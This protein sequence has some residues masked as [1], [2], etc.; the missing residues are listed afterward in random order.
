MLPRASYYVGQFF[1]PRVKRNTYILPSSTEKRRTVINKELNI[2]STASEI[3]QVVD[4]LRE[5]YPLPRPSQTQG[6]KTNFVFR[7]PVIKSDIS[8]WLDRCKKNM[9]EKV[10]GELNM[11]QMPKDPAIEFC[12]LSLIE[13]RVAAKMLQE[14]ISRIDD[15]LIRI[16][17]HPQ[18]DSSAT[19][20]F[21][22]MTK[23]VHNKEL[24][25]IENILSRTERQ[26]FQLL[27]TIMNNVVND[28][29]TEE[30]V[31]N[32]SKTAAEKNSENVISSQKP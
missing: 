14:E 8:K 6:G 26:L 3:H 2:G 16:W 20:D 29:V 1:D 31:K 13:A 28:I 10:L 23:E 9:E 15:Q 25:K 11:S 18:F 12:L 22:L 24:V 5:Q 17:E 32:L 7:E 4:M 27:P 21:L 19:E 30:N